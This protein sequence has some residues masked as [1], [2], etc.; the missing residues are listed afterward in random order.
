MPKC[1]SVKRANKV[2]NQSLK[3]SQ[4]VTAC[5]VRF[6][7]RT[8]RRT[9]LLWF[10][11]NGCAVRY[12]TIPPDCGVNMVTFVG[13]PWMC[14][15]TDSGYQVLINHRDVFT[16]TSGTDQQ[17]R[18][19]V[20]ITIPGIHSFIHS[21]RPFL[22]RLFK[23]LL[24]G[25]APDTARILCRNFTPKHH[26]Q[27]WVKDLPKVPTWQLERESNPWPFGRKAPTLPKRH[28]APQNCFCDA[29]I[30]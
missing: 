24:L 5:H 14:C 4:S 2:A 18:T 22:L 6:E 10:D 13:H 17:S 7:N 30:D 15:D 28:H 16:A 9:D 26:R 1:K 8:T 23:P 3:S 12:C 19:T 25:G 11:Y 29:Q 20:M 27:L 21:F